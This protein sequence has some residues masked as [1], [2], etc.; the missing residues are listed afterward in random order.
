MKLK[1]YDKAEQP[2]KEAL[3]IYKQLNP[4]SREVATWHHNLADCYMMQGK[5]GEA[6]QP[7]KE[8]LA[9]YKQ[10]NPKSHEVANSH[11]NWQIAT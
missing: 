11:Q 9:I 7:C 3:A 10:L 8:A 5:Y 6:E 2:C 4:K 1:K